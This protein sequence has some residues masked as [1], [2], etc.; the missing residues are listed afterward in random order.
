MQQ[1][2]DAT[3]HLKE[4]AMQNAVNELRELF[5]LLHQ[6]VATCLT[7]VQQERTTNKVD[8]FWR[9]AYVR[10]VFAFIEG[11]TYRM[12]RLAFEEKDKSQ[13]DFSPAEIALL[14]EQTFDLDEQGEVIHRTIAF[15]LT[16]NVR[17]AFKAL[18]RV[19]AVDYDLHGGAGWEAL[20]KSL[21]LR[22]RLMCPKTQEDLLIS[23]DEIDFVLSGSVWFVQNFK[24]LFNRLL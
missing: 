1:F 21:K 10:S 24:E 23:N 17:F 8:L 11:V 5:Q 14:L 4:P 3:N 9:R 19:N 6:D 13:V 15:P 2:T 7:M 12:K 22:E 20:K 16:K 18:A